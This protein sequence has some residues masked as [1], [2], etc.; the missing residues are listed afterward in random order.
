MHEA[1][2]QDATADTPA[3]LRTVID[4]PGLLWL[5]LDDPMSATLDDLAASRGFHEL[6]VDD[7]RNQNQLAKIDHYDNYDFVIINT[8]RFTDEPCEVSLH[9]IDVF[10]GAGYIVTV[11]FGASHAVNEVVKKV[12]SN[13]T[14]LTRPDRVMHAIIDVVVDR[15]LPTLDLIGDTIDTVQDKLLIN[16]DVTLL[17]TIFDLKR[18]LLQFRRAVSS[19]RELLNTLIRDETPY[20]HIDLQMYFRDV[21]DH[22]V[23]AMDM[24]ETYRDLLTGGLDIYL[25]QMANRTNNIVKALTIL[26]TIIL[27][28]T[29]V[30]GY[31][32]MNFEYVPLAKQ[33][34]GIWYTTAGL[35]AI[36]A[37]ML[38]WFKYR[39]WL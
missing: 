28:L 27:P 35:L 4:Q 33:P 25:T 5:D 38:A 15:Y 24:V 32:G 7:C 8:T 26:A 9:E 37:A 36:T 11:H 13:G 19:Q 23:R 18:G 1:I 22:A 17:E 21:Y 30:T 34:G 10:L 12:S 29:L 3:D 2:L 20:I 14:H 6:A 16:P 39:K 31:F